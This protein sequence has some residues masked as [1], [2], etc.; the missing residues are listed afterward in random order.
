[1]YRNVQRAQIS[2]IYELIL[3]KNII[4]FMGLMC[5]I[6]VESDELTQLYQEERGQ[7]YEVD[8]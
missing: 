6:S 2:T 1:M 8:D 5:Y 7:S 3:A 4:Y